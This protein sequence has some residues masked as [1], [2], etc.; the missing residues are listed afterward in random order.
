MPPNPSNNSASS[1][2]LVF[3][4]PWVTQRD[5]RWFPEPLRFDPWR[6]SPEMKAALPRFAH[7][8]FGGGPR[9]CIG[10]SFAWMEA[11]LLVAAIAQRWRL[12]LVPGQEIV[13]HPSITLR[14]KNGMVM[15]L[16]ARE[17]G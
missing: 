16:E 8:P 3:V 2:L 14:P 7:F 17:G 10:E 13:P 5:G 6:W 1:R 4:S 9:Q 12:R 11:V 15:R